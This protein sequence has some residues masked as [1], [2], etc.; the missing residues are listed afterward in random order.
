[1]VTLPGDSIGNRVG[2]AVSLAA[3]QAALIARN[4]DDYVVLI[5]RLLRRP[6]FAR[7]LGQQLRDNRDT[8]PLWDIR[9]CVCS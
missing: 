4:L 8:A 6:R 9:R 7:V 2:A 3:G 1:M 5:H